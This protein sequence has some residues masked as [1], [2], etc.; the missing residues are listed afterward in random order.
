MP[1][2]RFAKLPIEQQQVIL[3]AAL[4]EFASRGFHAASINRVIEAARISKGSMY[5][6]FDGK[7][8]L[9]A[10]LL[11]HELQRFFA[12]AGPF[13]VPMDGDADAFWSALEGYCL[14]LM[15]ALAASPPLAALLRSW[16]S[17]T[18]TPP[19]QEAQQELEEAT[20]PWLQQTLAAGQ[21]V[22]AIRSDLPSGLLIA[23]VVGMGQAMDTWIITQQPDQD[24]LPR[25]IRSLTG[26]IRG[27]VGVVQ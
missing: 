21:R 10:Y 3:Q 8:D 12:A 16:S 2:R 5:Y 7:E 11:Q 23:V 4:E 27:A 9:Y 24:D 25:Q 15:A 14:R 6:Y 1:R 17:A 22:G 20:R 19:L 18:K 26:M 13:P